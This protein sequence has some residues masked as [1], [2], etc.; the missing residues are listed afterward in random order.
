MPIISA[1]AGF[2][3]PSFIRDDPDRCRSIVRVKNI[4]NSAEFSTD[5]SGKSQATQ[6]IQE[7]KKHILSKN[8]VEESP[9]IGP[10]PDPPL[11][12]QTLFERVVDT[13]RT[14][15]TSFQH[16]P[17]AAP[18][19]SYAFDKALLSGLSSL[20]PKVVTTSD[21]ILCRPPISQ[22]PSVALSDF[23]LD[24]TDMI[25]SMISGGAGA[26]TIGWILSGAVSL[27]DLANVLKTYSSNPDERLQKIGSVM[28]HAEDII[29]LFSHETD[30]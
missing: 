20:Q 19:Q 8:T 27:S 12:L 9:Y 11:P 29:S 22:N 26:A 30:T 5:V 21:N 1:G 16:S 14:S 15:S 2:F 23:S 13:T 25:S 4:K 18:K 3:H 17:A 28:D 6:R 24:S 10:R 7:I